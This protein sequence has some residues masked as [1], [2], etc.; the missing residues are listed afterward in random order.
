MKKLAKDL[1]RHFDAKHINGHRVQKK[2]LSISNHQ[3]SANQ[4]DKE[5][6]PHTCQDGCSQK[7]KR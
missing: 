6:S 4:V 7:D 1:N 3:K 5:L 2:V